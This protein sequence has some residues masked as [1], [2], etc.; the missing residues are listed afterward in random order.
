MPRPGW[1][2]TQIVDTVLKALRHNEASGVRGVRGRERGGRT[3]GRCG[4]LS[5]LD[6]QCGAM[7]ACARRVAI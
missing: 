1:T 4:A 6:G 7:L 2:P 5:V 3:P